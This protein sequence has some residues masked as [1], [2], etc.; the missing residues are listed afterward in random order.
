[1]LFSNSRT[2]QAFEGKRVLKVGSHWSSKDRF[3]TQ[4][5]AKPLIAKAVVWGSRT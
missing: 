2:L 1:M 5:E 3:V 4:F